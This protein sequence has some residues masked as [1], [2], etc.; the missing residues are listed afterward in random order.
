MKHIKLTQWGVV[1][2]KLVDA[3]IPHL[4]AM[5]YQFIKK[6]ERTHGPIHASIPYVAK[7]QRYIQHLI[8]LG[9]LKETKNQRGRFLETTHAKLAPLNSRQTGTPSHAKLA[10]PHAKVASGPMPNWHPIEVNDRSYI[11]KLKNRDVGPRDLFLDWYNSATKEEIQETI[12]QAMNHATRLQVKLLSGPD[13]SSKV[14]A[15]RNYWESQQ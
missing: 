11:S 15:L 4:E 7:H 2:F 13:G 5:V 1:D 6:F 10:Q 9:L 14:S 12:N 3:G 8:K